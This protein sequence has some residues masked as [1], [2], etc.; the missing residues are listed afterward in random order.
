MKYYSFALVF[1]SIWFY[2]CN[3][4]DEKK[5]YALLSMKD[6]WLSHPVLGDPSF[7]NFKRYDHNPLQRGSPPFLW[8]VNGFYFED[9]V[10]GNEYVFAAQYLEGYAIGSS[11]KALNI[12]KGCTVFCSKDQGKTW[13]NGIIMCLRVGE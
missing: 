12:S 6:S 4:S 7:D 13:G 1:I 2:S 9:P 8:P 3:S 11:E 5:D 10:S